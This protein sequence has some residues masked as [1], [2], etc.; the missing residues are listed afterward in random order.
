MKWLVN[1]LT[2]KKDEQNIVQKSN[3]LTKSYQEEDSCVLTNTEKFMYWNDDRESQIRELAYYKWEAA[4]RPDGQDA[5]FWD[6]AEK[7]VDEINE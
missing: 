6:E 7:E 3:E 4:G 2:R 1:Y 5:Q